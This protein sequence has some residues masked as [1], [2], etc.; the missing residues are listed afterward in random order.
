LKKPKE[1]SQVGSSKPSTERG[2]KEGWRRA[3]LIVKKENLKKI[4]AV[5]YW[6]RKDIKEVVDEAFDSY[7]ENK[8]PEPIKKM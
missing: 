2:L 4:K 8:N 5:A 7:L 1:K 3:T 6:E